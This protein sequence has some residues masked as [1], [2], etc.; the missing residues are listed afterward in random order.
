MEDPNGDRRHGQTV[1][2]ASEEAMARVRAYVG[3]GSNVGDAEPTL[4]GAIEALEELAATHVT[5]VSSLYATAPVGVVDQPEFRNAVVALDVLTI[6]GELGAIGLLV[7]LK[8]IERS[9]GR[10]QR[11]RWGPREVD[12]DLL[13]FGRWTGTV[14]RP[15]AGA[16]LDPAKAGQGLTVPHPEA[17]H[18]AFVLVP[19]A[20]IAPRLVPPG[21]GET[22][23]TAAARRVAIEGPDA[24]RPVARWTGSGWVGQDQ[25]R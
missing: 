16:S 7:S 14:D 5:R 6:P 8:A 10:R 12:L 15:I 2:H 20:E 24:V 23:A 19:L 13:V 11:E 9:F 1:A 21:W 17:R 25:R 4:V 18:R 3:L 22:V